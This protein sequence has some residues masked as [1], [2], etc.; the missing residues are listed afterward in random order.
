MLLLR[1]DFDLDLLSASCRFGSSTEVFSAGT[2]SLEKPR[3]AKE[4]DMPETP[5]WVNGAAYTQLLPAEQAI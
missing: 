4:L 3:D 5:F 2:S 1:Y